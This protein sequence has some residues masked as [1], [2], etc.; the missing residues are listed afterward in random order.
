VDNMT[1]TSAVEGM[2]EK[3]EV[4]AHDLT[5]VATQLWPRQARPASRTINRRLNAH[6]GFVA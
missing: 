2:I 5:Q 6:L 1:L 3:G 4:S